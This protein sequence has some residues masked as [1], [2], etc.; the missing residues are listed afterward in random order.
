M[1]FRLIVNIRQVTVSLSVR[2]VI[3]SYL[4]G[5]NKPGHP[6]NACQHS[7]SLSPGGAVQCNAVQCIVVQCNAVQCIVVQCIAVQCD[8]VQCSAVQ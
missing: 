5:I 6:V 4:I 1:R 3:P 2:S 8:A 7:N